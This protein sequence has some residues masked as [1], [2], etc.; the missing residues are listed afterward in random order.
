MRP[1]NQ[2]KIDYIARESGYWYVT[3]FSAAGQND[4]TLTVVIPDEPPA[5]DFAVRSISCLSF[6][7]RTIPDVL[8]QGC[9][10]PGLEYQ[11]ELI[12]PG[13]T[14][15]WHSPAILSSSRYVLE[16]SAYLVQGAGDYFVFFEE[17][18][19]GDGYYAFGVRP[20]DGTFAL[21]RIDRVNGTETWTPLIDWTASSHIRRDTLTNRLRVERNG[22]ELI[23]A[24]NGQQVG[25]AVDETYMGSEFGLYANAIQ[26]G[27]IIR[28][29]NIQYVSYQ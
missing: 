1:D 14:Q 11:I 13:W 25:A 21:M 2:E 10:S 24:V 28:F 17:F 15:T 22:P 6:T 12:T 29:E 16:V 9:R 19:F 20:H 8:V 18:E 7:A 26:S 5:G 27:S 4:Y 23:V 3:V